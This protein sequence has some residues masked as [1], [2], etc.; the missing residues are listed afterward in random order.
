MLNIYARFNLDN[1]NRVPYPSRGNKIDL[2]VKE[3]NHFT[4]GGV[5]PAV[6]VDLRYRL[7]FELSPKLSLQPSLVTSL[8]FGDSI[9]YPYRSYLGGLG[10]YHKSVVPFVGCE[11]MERA[12]NHAVVLRADL[13]YRIRG[14]HYAIWK[15]NIGKTF[16]AFDQFMDASAT[17]F[18]TG[19]TYG[20]SSP[21]GP[22][23]VTLMAASG[24]WK[25]MLFINL[26]YWIH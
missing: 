12:S 7:A 18:G 10:Y 23:E 1:F 13:Q 4:S 16:D 2:L 8:S 22:V 9:P 25:P 20:Y 11:Y 6:V 3:V 21:V 26:G 15:T 14:N 17:V 5:I 19:L 24:S